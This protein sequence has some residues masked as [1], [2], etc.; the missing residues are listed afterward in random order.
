MK[1]ETEDAVA[2]D[3]GGD[4]A[5]VVDR[6]DDRALV[7]GLDRAMTEAAPA[8]KDDRLR[9]EDVDVRSRDAH[10]FGAGTP[11]RRVEAREIP[12]P[13]VDDRDHPMRPFELGTPR[14]RV[15][16]CDAASSARP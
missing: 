5:T 4:G 9:R 2:A 7:D 8:R 11:E 1:L 14:R 6:S 10:V 13:V 3:R 15:S 16:R 12:H